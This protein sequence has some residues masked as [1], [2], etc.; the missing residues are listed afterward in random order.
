MLSDSD[1]LTADSQLKL[2]TENADSVANLKISNQIGEELSIDEQ[3]SGDE[4]QL[5]ENESFALINGAREVIHK[6]SSK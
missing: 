1:S 3:S 4:R 5:A 2:K 6:V